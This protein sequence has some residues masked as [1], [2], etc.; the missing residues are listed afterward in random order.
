MV[1]KPKICGQN[2]QSFNPIPTDDTNDLGFTK[3]QRT[4]IRAKFSLFG[5]G[6]DS[7]GFIVPGELGTVMR[8]L[9]RNPTEKDL[10]DMM[11]EVGELIDIRQFMNFF[12]RVPSDAQRASVK[13]NDTNNSVS[14]PAKRRT[15]VA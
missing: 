10:Q 8:S 12:E 6:T 1:Q 15:A 7:W 3:D 14:P 11:R 2:F 4:T 9:G 5:D 13:R